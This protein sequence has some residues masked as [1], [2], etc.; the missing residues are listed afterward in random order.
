M[1]P[2]PTN[3][4]IL[5]PSLWAL[6]AAGLILAARLR[7]IHL[8][9][10]DVAINDQW[11]IE[12]ADLLAP[13]LDGTLKPWA[14]F[15][16]HFE[17]V[18]MWTRLTAWLEVV[19][20][21]RW[22]PAVQATVNALLYSG[23]A[24]LLVRWVVAN[25]K[26]ASALGVT[27]L[28]IIGSALPHAWENIT[29]G[30]QSQFPFAL[31]FLFLHVQGSFASAPGS[32]RWWWAQAAGLAGL[33]T[34]A[35]M[36]IAPLSVVLV[37]LWIQP[38]GPRR[39]YLP[40]TLVA[41][42]LGIIAVIRATAPA[43]GAFA[44]TAGSPLHFLHALL[45]LLGWPAGWPGALALLNLPLL[46]F[47]LQLRGRAATGAFD[48]TVLALGVWALG[49][50]TA[51]AFA[52]SAD[53]GG[54][55][56]RYGELLLPL[57]LANAL[58]LARLVPAAP[59]WRPATIAYAG[60]WAGVVLTGWWQLSHGGHTAHFHAHSAENARLRRGAVQA[61]LQSGDRTALERQETR[62]V[63]YQDV[64]QI[65]RLLDQPAFR[66]L[67][68]HSVHS[69]N[70]PDLAGTVVRSLLAHATFCGGLAG[71]M[72]IGGVALTLRRRPPGD[73]AQ[74]DLTLRPESLLPWLA[75]GTAVAAAALLFCWP[76]PLTFD[77][78]ER[79]R[80]LF[81]PPGSVGPLQVRI[82][83]GSTVY[84]PERLVGAAP[85]EPAGL[86]GQFTGTD[87]EGPALTCTAWSE[88]FPVNAPWF[89]V[90]YAGWPVAH[91]NGLRLRIEESD[92]RV[93]TE[94]ACGGPHVSG[95]GFWTADVRPYQGK[96]ARLVL[97]D[98]RTE[99]DAW[100]AAA[101]PIAT[102]DPALAARL[103]AGLARERLADTHLALGWLAAAAT[104][105]C[106]GA[107]TLGRSGPNPPR[108]E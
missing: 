106:G 59:R 62:W 39:R 31:L 84:P 14:F 105:V 7:E 58:A 52:R 91:G 102:A 3:R 89:I 54:Y 48:R 35:G 47:A 33:F 83:H 77:R 50:A 104:L 5:P 46:L 100:V 45:D 70:P 90:P 4:P 6:G 64:G 60:A 99:T 80:R 94:V 16:P 15:A 32:R 92:G 37:T 20:T 86:R 88:S 44:Q 10:G 1:T 49:Q 93:I 57:V 28:F 63:L 107:V 43:Y 26:T 79:W 25:L 73:E 51:L 69:A 87:P 85:L 21:G 27:L 66:A 22:N 108:P 2:G 29:W 11:K 34:L 72:L 41:A 38:R 8:H 36:W 101:P 81:S 68:P 24:V 55:V 23:F 74:P 71:L 76:A 53:Y 30:F 9:T 96:T 65:T 12:A 19:L 103:A 75:G 13:W 17:H 98:G 42:G 82:Q 97:Y 61:Y 67:L 18:P 40:L 95:V 56:S 78:T